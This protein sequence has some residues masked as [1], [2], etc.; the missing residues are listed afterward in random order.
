MQPSR[1]SPAQFRDVLH[2]ILDADAPLLACIEHQMLVLL[3]WGVPLAL[4]LH[5]TYA[6]AIFEAASR[7]L[8]R[9]VAAPQV[10]LAPPHLPG[11]F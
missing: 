3:D 10:V 9:R 1:S 5:Q 2:D 6:N 7:E 8:G 11:G 4:G